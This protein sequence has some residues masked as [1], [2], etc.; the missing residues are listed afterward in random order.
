MPTVGSNVGT[1]KGPF[2]LVGNPA[3]GRR[4]CYNQ[5]TGVK[6][7]FNDIQPKDLGVSATTGFVY[8]GYVTCPYPNAMITSIDTSAAE[9]AGAITLSGLDTEYLPQYNYYATSG[10]RTRGP[11]PY[12]QVRSAG[13]AVVAVGAAS[14]DLVNDAINLV[15]VTYKPLPYVFDA[16]EALEPGAPQLW[17]GGNSP[18]GTITN[19]IAAAAT[20]VLAIGNTAAAIE[21]A[22]TVVTLPALDTQWGQ[23]MELD[24]RGAIVQ[25]TS[26]GGVSTSGGVSTTTPGVTINLW[27]NSQNVTG[28]ASTL[29][30][31]FFIPAANINSRTNLGGNDATTGGCVDGG[32]FGNKLSAEEIVVAAAMSKKSGGVVK[33]AQTRY[34]QA[35]FTVNRYPFRAY[36]TIAAKNGL[37]TALEAVEYCNVGAVA[38]SESELSEFYAV[39]NI[40]NVNLVSYPVNTNAYYEAAA[41]RDVGESQCSFFCETAVDMLAEKLNIDPAEFRLKN[42]RTAAY[43]DPATGDVYPDTA[44]DPSTGYPFSGFGQPACHLKTTAAFNWSG[45]WKGWGVPSGTPVNSGE[46]QGTGQKLRG[47]GLSLLSGAK[48]SLSAVPHTITVTPAGV[49]TLYSGVMDHGAGGN[50]AMPL[51][52]AECLGLTPATFSTLQVVMSD[53]T[54]TPNAGSTGGSTGTRKG[55]SIITA[56]QNLASQWFP[57]VAAKLATGTQAANLAFGNNTIYDTTN[58]TN[59]MT[60]TKAA[61]LLTTTLVGN[62]TY[63]APAKTAY[64]VGGTKICEVEVDVDTA[65]VRVINA[66][67]GIGLGRVIFALGAE[68]QVQGGFIGEGIGESLYEEIINDSSTGLKYSGGILN[69]DYLD[70]KVPT[71]MQAP[72]TAQAVYE[73]Y[74]DQYGPFGAVGIGENCLTG[75]IPAILNA[76]SNAMGGYRFTKT[77]VRK[78]DIVAALQWMKAN[79]KLPS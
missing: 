7:Y 27:S 55:N 65:D 32:A 4:A 64:R 34:G 56:A 72:D 22:D 19:S 41:M 2:A 31:Y 70:F 66:V 60:L 25:W 9:A 44:F 75:C 38:G 39:Y 6:R 68:G 42:M 73:E 74:V 20:S 40:P 3:V 77:P 43:T 46:T 78:E 62:G 18:G 12:P 33:F 1:S 71:I 63:T 37:I 49:I 11:L 79:G 67:L 61:S 52:A 15:K 54:L 76:L 48:G 8:M 36:V 10:N 14:P 69:G 30:S 23:H 35:R 24:T 45:R 51:Q 28:F 58:P 5:I 53:T 26:T 17:P 21:E 57:I 29:S 50:T 47:V 16:E 59:S 13:S